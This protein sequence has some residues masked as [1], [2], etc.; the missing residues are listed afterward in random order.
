[1]SSAWV[2]KD[3]PSKRSVVVISFG[4]INCFVKN[5][6]L[7]SNLSVGV[8][9]YQRASWS[10]LWVSK[11]GSD[12]TRSHVITG[13]WWW[14]FMTTG[15]GAVVWYRPVCCVTYARVLPYE[16]AKT[17][18]P[19]IRSLL[20]AT[21]G[22]LRK[23]LKSERVHTCVFY[24]EGWLVIIVIII[25]GLPLKPPHHAARLITGFLWF[26]RNWLPVAKICGGANSSCL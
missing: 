22:F 10:Q 20:M 13:L 14:W 26:S 2:K 6:Y 4:K 23:G 19:Y 9:G 7:R 21:T 3:R 18:Q 17:F 16:P 5:L 15:S 24:R 1:M 8:L 25:L 12:V 11:V